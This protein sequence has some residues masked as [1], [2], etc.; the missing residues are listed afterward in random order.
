M[1]S[2][3]GGVSD[4]IVDPANKIVKKTYSL[5]TVY[6]CESNDFHMVNELYML[7]FLK[8]L[9]GF[10]QLKDI[11]KETPTE[12]TIVMSYNGKTINQVPYD[13]KLFIQLVNRLNT[14]H[15]HGIAHCDLKPLNITVSDD[16]V[17]SIIDFSHAHLIFHSEII[18]NPTPTKTKGRVDF[19]KPGIVGWSVNPT[20]AYA[21]PETLYGFIKPTEKVDL[22]SLGCVLYEWITGKILFRY[23]SPNQPAEVIESQVRY[24]I[25]ES[26]YSDE[27]KW[28]LALLQSDP[29]KR[30]PLSGFG[31]ELLSIEKPLSIKDTP[32][33]NPQ[34]LSKRR[35]YGYSFPD[36]LN[37]CVDMWFLEILN[38]LPNIDRYD[39]LHCVHFLLSLLFDAEIAL[40]YD[41]L[42]KLHDFMTFLK[43]II[44]NYQ[45]PRITY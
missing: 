44:M 26:S 2:I 40:P 41:T 20:L 16:N 11:T 21:P 10:P 27:I 23:Q 14:L 12:Y 35:M 45:F 6:T 19:S 1:F 38:T 9:P 3:S 34:L 4:V 7:N 29:D 39:L 37:P 18:P 17:V 42:F 15:Q 32:G 43:V 5:N 24:H 8:G 28:I 33:Y 36:A 30:T 13:R 22:W 25:P 31:S